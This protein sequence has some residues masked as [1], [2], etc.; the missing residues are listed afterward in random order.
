MTNKSIVCASTLEHNTVYC[1]SGIE[2]VV[3]SFWIL[4]ILKKM[5]V[6]DG[7]KHLNDAVKS[8]IITMKTHSSLTNQEIAEQCDCSVS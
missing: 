5:L 4:I 7:N 8:K 3:C 1:E 6:R 2:F